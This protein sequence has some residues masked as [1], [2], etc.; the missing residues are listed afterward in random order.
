MNLRRHFAIQPQNERFSNIVVF[1]FSVLVFGLVAEKTMPLSL[2][3]FCSDDC[4]LIN[5]KPEQHFLH[6]SLLFKNGFCYNQTFMFLI[7]LMPVVFDMHI[8]SNAT[9]TEI[10]QRCL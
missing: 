9:N 1:L 8:L 2:L 5:D 7:H 6:F 10:M 4:L 3:H